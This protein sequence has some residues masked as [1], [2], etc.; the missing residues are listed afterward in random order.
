M[1]AWHAFRALSRGQV[2][3]FVVYL[4]LRAALSMASSACVLILVLVT[5]CVAGCIMAIPV[6]GSV[7]L[8]PISVFFRL[9]AVEFLGQFSPELDFYGGDEPATA[10]VA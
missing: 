6:L 3:T 9:Y 2:G 7:L 8:L 10:A 1:E 5:C 4:L